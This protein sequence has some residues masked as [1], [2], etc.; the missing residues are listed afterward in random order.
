MADPKKPAS[1]PASPRVT[2]ADKSVTSPV[3]TRPKPV[4]RVEEPVRR[5]REL[6]E[7]EV[8]KF[9]PGGLYRMVE[10]KSG[11]IHDALCVSVSENPIDGM[12]QAFFFGS[13]GMVNV[14]EGS[15]D[16]EGWVF[17]G[18]RYGGVEAL[19]TRAE[20]EEPPARGLRALA[21]EATASAARSTED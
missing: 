15:E 8:Q 6:A 9:I 14:V 11:V 13:T 3:V 17:Q 5:P 12:R 21:A 20:V 7:G 18:V 10:R 16:A 4:A 1:S 19:V 2:V